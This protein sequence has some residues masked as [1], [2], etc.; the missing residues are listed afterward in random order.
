M[1]GQSS[2]TEPA[3]AEYCATIAHGI[4]HAEALQY[5]CNWVASFDTKLPNII[6]DQATYRYSTDNGKD[7]K[8]MDTTSARIAYIDGRPH[9][10]D[11]AI[12]HVKIPESAD[13]S[14]L[15]KFSGA[16]SYTDYGS[17]L[18]MLFG[19]HTN[20][21]FSYAGE[22]SWRGIPV[23]AF[24]YEM[25]REDNHRWQMKAREKPG[26]P[27]ASTYPGYAG[28]ILL[29]R[30]TSALLRFERHTT[31]IEKHFPLRFG[32][33]Q[34]NY[35]RVALGDGTFFVLPVES[36]VSFCHDEKHRKCEVND[37]TFAN[38]QKFGAKT[39]I[40]TGTQPE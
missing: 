24:A 19:S 25:R 6:G 7:L 40:L 15:T 9:V 5:F 11:L 36:I 2:P 18:R 28:R 30:Q 16:W 34:V 3:V 10:S 22:T 12:N 21:H 17:D 29:D 35:Q 27:L 23:V 26:Q 8:L 37:T 38:W 33:N 14:E 4:P 39:R 20:T 13:A 32:S 31:E 1:I